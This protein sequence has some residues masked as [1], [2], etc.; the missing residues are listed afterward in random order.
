MKQSEDIMLKSSFREH[1]IYYLWG[2]ALDKLK[3]YGEAVPKYEQSIKI[4]EEDE[5]VTIDF[6]TIK[7]NLVKMRLAFSLLCHSK[8]LGS[9]DEYFA[10]VNR[11][12]KI[13]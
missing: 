5:R 7:L 6:S 10:T 8:N 3:K 9:K 13:L 12:I 1:Q 11:A 2:K 4:M